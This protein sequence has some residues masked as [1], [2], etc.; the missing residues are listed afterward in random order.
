MFSGLIQEVGEVASIELVGV[1]HT[2]RIMAPKT[3]ARAMSGS[4]IAI[5]GVCMTLTKSERGMLGF[6]VMPVT[7]EKTTL[8]AMRMG[9][10]V[11]IEGALTVGE[12]IG[13]HFVYGHVDDTARVVEVKENGETR[14][15]TVELPAHT[16]RYIALQGSIAIDGVSLTIAGHTARTATVSLAPYTLR[17]TTLATLKSGDMVNIEVDILAKYVAINKN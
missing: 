10:L 7:L 4:S 8:A 5:A 16:M 14:L 12:E 11:N 13:G 9:T 2:I 17:H 3:A 15:L 1:I 6:D